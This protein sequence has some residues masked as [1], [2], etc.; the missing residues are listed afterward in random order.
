MIASSLQS[1]SKLQLSENE[2]DTTTLG[3]KTRVL[4]T[5]EVIDLSILILTREKPKESPLPMSPLYTVPSHHW[6]YQLVLL[7]NPTWPWHHWLTL[8]P[9]YHLVSV[10]LHLQDFSEVGVV[11]SKPVSVTSREGQGFLWSLWSLGSVWSSWGWSWVGYGFRLIRDWSRT[12]GVW[13]WVKCS[14]RM[15]RD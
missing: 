4:E 10:L 6:G 7:D 9:G 13:S 14:F 12:F 3:L 8:D 5:D 1:Q 11:D 2:A 15:L